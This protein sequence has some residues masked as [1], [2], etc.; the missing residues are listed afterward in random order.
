MVAPSEQ[1]DEVI[2]LLRSATD[3][4]RQT[5][6]R[7]A[8]IVQL[9]EAVA[10]DVL[11]A[12]DLHGQRLNFD[13]LVRRADLGNHPRRHLIM[14]EVCHGGP[15]YPASPGCMSHLLLEDVA[16]LKT[17]YPD[18]FHFIL[19]NHELAELTD[20]PIMKANRMLNLAFRNGMEELYGERVEQVRQAYLNFLRTCP[21]AVRLE[22]RIFISHSAPDQLAR[23][24]FDNG[25]FDRPLEAT[26]FEPRGPA[27][28]LV[29]GRDFSQ[30]NADLFAE[31][32]DAEVLIHG[33]EPAVD[34]FQV[35][36]D[37]QVIL[38]CCGQRACFVLVP[39]SG[40]IT[41]GE[42][43]SR[44]QRLWPDQSSPAAGRAP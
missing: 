27:F 1:I 18:R 13:E 39:A 11:I 20:F 24:G 32:V 7:Q 19:S 17:T 15:T 9:G 22:S 42:V 3:A 29:W 23:D 6:T 26:D 34:G 41:H 30:E 8:N 2:S 25:L 21:L 37:K 12:T 16:L 44:I 38:D 40:S 14:Q 31:I 28:R 35:P 36:N 33:H 5:G 43:V 4:N 10:D